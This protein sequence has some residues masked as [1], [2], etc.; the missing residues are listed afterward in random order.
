MLVWFSS[1]HLV[2]VH[3]SKPDE[4]LTCGACDKTFFDPSSLKRH[5]ATFHATVTFSCDVCSAT[6]KTKSTL[7]G[8]IQLPKSKREVFKMFDLSTTNQILQVSF[9]KSK[10]ARGGGERQ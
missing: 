3:G 4:F 7:K 10:G 9:F 8:D 1:D 5:R 2:E 6:F